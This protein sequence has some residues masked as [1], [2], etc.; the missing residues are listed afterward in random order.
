MAA[1]ILLL[2]GFCVLFFTCDALTAEV[3][4]LDRLF[5]DVPCSCSI[6]CP[7][8]RNATF[9]G[10]RLV[11]LDNERGGGGVGTGSRPV[12]STSP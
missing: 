3:I 11:L 6:S 2:L 1:V 4:E 7:E 10:A 5:D 12:I 9:V 8:L